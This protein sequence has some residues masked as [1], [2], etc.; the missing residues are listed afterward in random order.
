MMHYTNPLIDIHT[1]VNIRVYNDK[2]LHRHYKKFKRD[3][4]KRKSSDDCRKLVWTL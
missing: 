2:L 4:L 3:R 1:E